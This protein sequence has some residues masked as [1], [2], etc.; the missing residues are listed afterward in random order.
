[1]APRP[2]VPVESG[3]LTTAKP[4]NGAPAAR[5]PPLQV[6]WLPLQRRARGFTLT[7]LAVTVGVVGL[8]IFLLAQLLNTA[9]NVITLGH[10]QMDADSQTRQLLDRIQ[11]KLSRSHR[12]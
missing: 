1:M 9:A 3:A 6:R 4:G 5:L 10:K 7:E 11:T 2:K 12:E 8:L